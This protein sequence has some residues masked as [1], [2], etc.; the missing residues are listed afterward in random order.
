MKL[1]RTVSGAYLRVS[2]RLLC[3]EAVR[4]RGSHVRITP[5][6]NGECH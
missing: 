4:R 5:Q 2:L 6:V 3:S 1:P